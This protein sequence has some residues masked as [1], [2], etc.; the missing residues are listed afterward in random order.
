MD[1]IR[2]LAIVLVVVGHAIGSSK[3]INPT[4]DTISTFVYLFHIPMFALAAGW[5]AQR[6]TASFTGLAKMTWQV[7]VPYVV[8]QSI[9]IVLGRWDGNGTPWQ[10]ATPAFALWFLVSL[11]LWRLLAPWF[12]SNAYGVAAAVLVTLLAG[13]VPAIG[14]PLSLSRCASSRPSWSERRTATTSATGWTVAASGSSARLS[15]SPPWSTARCSP[16]R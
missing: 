10:Y 16:T 2:L 1:N 13:F 4:A 7:L 6:L 15:W 3:G 12:R 5:T 14:E 11:F 8:F 9:A